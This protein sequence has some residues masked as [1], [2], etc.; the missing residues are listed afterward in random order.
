MSWNISGCWGYGGRGKKPEKILSEG[1]HYYLGY[2]IIE[3][4]NPTAP[5]LPKR[6]SS[7]EFS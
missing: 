3:V 5:H 1:L 4:C 2:E 7:S 6:S